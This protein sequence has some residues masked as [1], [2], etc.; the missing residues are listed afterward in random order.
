MITAL[1]YTL[2]ACCYLLL[3]YFTGLMVL[4]SWQYVP[5]RLD[6]A[7]LNMK[8][9]VIGRWYYQAAFFAH[10][11]TSIWVLIAGIPQ[12]SDYFRCR[13]P[14]AHKVIGYLYVLLLLL[15]AA[16]SGLVMA[17]YAN[18]GISS[19]VSFVLQAVLW[20]VFTYLAYRYAI[21]GSWEKHRRFMIRSYALTLS[22]ISL[23]LFKWVI[24]ATLAPPPMDTYKVVAWAGWVANLVIAELYIAYRWRKH[25]AFK[26]GQ[27]MTIK[28]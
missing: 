6:V 7:F 1:H 14:S 28:D 27:L 25:S 4:I 18:G 10:V 8:Q 24:V 15:V 9:Q 20:F 12:F 13:Y 19:Q 22:A 2:K 16:P 26:V 21:E 5:F 11:Y 17:W 23:R 3:A